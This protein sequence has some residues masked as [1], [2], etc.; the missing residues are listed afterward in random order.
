M[1]RSLEQTRA[2][3]GVG[4]I[5]FPGAITD[6]EG[7]GAINWSRRLRQNHYPTVVTIIRYGSNDV[8]LIHPR[9]LRDLVNAIARSMTRREF[10]ED[11]VCDGETVR[12]AGGDDNIRAI[13]LEH[14]A[15]PFRKYALAAA[16]DRVGG[17][18]GEGRAI[19]RRSDRIDAVVSAAGGK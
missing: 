18:H 5:H 16:A 3:P 11:C 6:G 14:A 4:V 9:N 7:A 10:D 19:R 13:L 17:R 15:V 2:E 12:R 8:E 1:Q